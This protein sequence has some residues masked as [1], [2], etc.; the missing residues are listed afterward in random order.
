MMG[1]LDSYGDI[2]ANIRYWISRLVNV[3][4]DPVIYDIGANDGALTVQYIPRAQV[5]AF[6]PNKRAR[7]RLAART[8]S[9]RLRIFPYALGAQRETAFLHVYSDDSFS[10]LHKRTEAEL[11]QY[12]LHLQ[13]V[14]Q[15]PVY[16]L[17][18]V[19]PQLPAPHIVKIDVEGA[20][21]DVLRGACTTLQKE[22]PAV[23]IEYSCV[24]TK[25]AGYDRAEILAELHGCNYKYIK[26]LWRNID[27]CLH[28]DIRDCRIWNLVCLPQHLVPIIMK[29][30]ADTHVKNNSE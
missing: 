6:E 12:S 30:T 24:N 9:S 13:E 23:L 25:N 29:D 20:E 3:F 15:V 14:A 26:G 28:D 16:A 1:L 10:S 2:H 18:E 27:T 5:F 4:P 22:Q 11:S 7:E 8:Q 19:S 21:R 17:D